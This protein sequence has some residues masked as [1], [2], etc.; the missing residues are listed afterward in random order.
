MHILYK[1]IFSLLFVTFSLLF[2]V[3]A[4]PFTFDVE[5]P[6][7]S[8]IP[9]RMYGDEYYNW[10]ETEDEYVIDFVDDDIY[11]GWY[12]NKLNNDGKYI[13][14]NV[15]ATYPAPININVPIQLRETSLNVR[16]L[17]S[18]TGN[19]LEMHNNHLGKVEIDYTLQPLVLLVEFTDEKHKYT[20]NQFEQLIFEQIL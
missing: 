9:V 4:P 20:A 14:S 3:S 18:K 6:D 7:G 5:Q 12:Y 19:I 17:Y 10:I 16:K 15:L 1:H 2:S 13:S 11:K 8:K